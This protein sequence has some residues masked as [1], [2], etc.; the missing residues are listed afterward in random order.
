[1][2][3]AILDFGSILRC[4]HGAPIQSPSVSR[5]VSLAGKPALAINDPLLIAGCP[6]CIP[7]VGGLTPQPCSRVVWATAPGRVTVE[8]QPVAL[9]DAA[10]VCVTSQGGA[11]GSVVAVAVQTRVLA[12]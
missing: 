3:S 4:P 12:G 7:D 8:G 1:M 6:F 10:G 9:A 2:P 11:Q 5:R